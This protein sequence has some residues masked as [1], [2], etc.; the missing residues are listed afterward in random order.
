MPT[1]L[2]TTCLQTERLKLAMKRRLLLLK[3]FLTKRTFQKHWCHQVKPYKEKPLHKTCLMPASVV[4]RASFNCLCQSL[5]FY[6]TQTVI[7]LLFHGLKHSIKKA[8]SITPVIIHSVLSLAPKQT[9]KQT[10]TCARIQGTSRPA[11]LHPHST[12]IASSPRRANIP[13]R[14]AQIYTEKLRINTIDTRTPPHSITADFNTLWPNGHRAA[15]T[16]R[17]LTAIN[18]NGRWWAGKSCDNRIYL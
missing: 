11:H 8:Q 1:S 4:I 18:H 10:D 12:S 6:C 3:H 2:S 14:S 5:C 16:S 9:P 7:C 13:H 15:H 17:Q